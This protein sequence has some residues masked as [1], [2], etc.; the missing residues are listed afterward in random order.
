MDEIRAGDAVTVAPHGTIPVQAAAMTVVVAAASMF[1]LRE[2]RVFA[3]PLLV[4]ILLAYAIE[5][6]VD[7]FMRCRLRRTPAVLAAALVIAIGSVAGARAARRQATTFLDALPTT[8]GAIE[9]AT[10]RSED[11]STD[12][13]RPGLLDHLRRAAEDLDAALG[14]APAPSDPHVR[15]V[16]A[17]RGLDVRDLVPSWD[18]L[19]FTGTQLVAIALL[20]LALLLAGD[21]LKRKLV[22]AAG[23]DIEQ[24]LLTAEVI[25]EIDRGIQRYLAAR[26]LISVIVA[27]ATALAMWSLGVQHSLALGAIAGVLN[28]V[29]FIGPTIGVV[30][31]AV[32]AFVQFHAVAATLEAGSLAAVIAALEGNLVTP[33]LTGRAGELNTVAVFVSVLFWGWLWGLWGLLLAVPVMVSIK[34]AADRIEPLQPL[35]ELLGR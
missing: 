6:L 29:P 11:Q 13:A 34:A 1:V 24:R 23:P 2:M 33:W 21:R 8:I 15:R 3:A 25:R 28:V 17:A 12:A 22:H 7:L 4:S 30:V 10:V 19:L 27:A 18:Q 35:G 32:V 5:P 20:T 26:V 14:G 16:A 9:Q 31:C